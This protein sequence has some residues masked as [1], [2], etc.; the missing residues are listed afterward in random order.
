MTVPICPVPLVH[1]DTKGRS[2][3][4]YLTC[5]VHSGNCKTLNVSRVEFIAPDRIRTRKP[6]GGDSWATINNRGCG[7]M[8]QAKR[9]AGQHSSARQ[10]RGQISKTSES[11][12]QGQRGSHRPRMDKQQP[13]LSTMPCLRRERR[14]GGGSEGDRVGLKTELYQQSHRQPVKAC[15][16]I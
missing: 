16:L 1:V 8:P 7:H 10:V 14:G 2:R 3:A 5:P 11:D 12:I 6:Q 4:V 9:G 15:L 13:L